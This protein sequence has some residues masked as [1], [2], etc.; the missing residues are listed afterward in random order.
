MRI[1]DVLAVATLL[2]PSAPGR[3]ITYCL[4]QQKDGFMLC[5][6]MCTFAEKHLVLNLDPVVARLLQLY[7]SVSWDHIPKTLYSG[8]NV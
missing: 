8:L 7:K 3:D 5:F 4:S 1:L 2:R 6:L